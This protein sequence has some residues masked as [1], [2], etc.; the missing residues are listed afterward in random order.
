[1]YT[2]SEY[3]IL[4]VVLVVGDFL[5]CNCISICYNFSYKSHQCWVRTV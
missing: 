2:I 1:V 3:S 4:V 5:H